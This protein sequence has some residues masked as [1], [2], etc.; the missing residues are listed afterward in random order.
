MSLLK[1]KD[2]WKSKTLE[3]LENDYWKKPD[4]DSYLVITCHELRKKPL[5]EFEAEDLRIM[6]GQSIGLNYLIPIALEFLNWNIFTDGDFHKGDLLK[7]VLK[8]EA[9]FWKEEKKMFKEFKRIIK[10]NE[11]LLQK[12]GV[13]FLNDFNKLIK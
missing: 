13:D 7:A 11:N 2:N 9:V 10:D 1:T 5:K 3:K 8:V 4:F 12:E 6:I